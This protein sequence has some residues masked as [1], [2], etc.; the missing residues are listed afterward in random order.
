MVVSNTSDL[1]VVTRADPEILN[2]GALYVGHHGSPTKKILGF[3]WSK[4]AK[5]MLETKVF[6]KAILSV[7]S[8]FLHFNESLP[9]KSYRSFKIYIRFYKKREKT[10]LQ[11]SIKKEKLRKF[12]LF[13]YNLL[14][15]I[16][17]TKH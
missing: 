6:G 5:K 14:M 11:Q 9:M 13:T 15:Y 3:K 7:I 12:T 17:V 2:R 1:L 16:Q 4:N 8:D 10:L